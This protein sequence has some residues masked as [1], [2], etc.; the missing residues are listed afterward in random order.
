VLHA[1]G[2]ERNPLLSFFFARYPYLVGAALKLLFSGAIA[3]YILWNATWS[4]WWQR[5]AR[6][7]L[8]FA[9]LLLV[10]V[11]LNNLAALAAQTAV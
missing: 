11:I 5:A 6:W 3:A 8:A 1:G 7:E 4:A 2:Y 9:T 10:F